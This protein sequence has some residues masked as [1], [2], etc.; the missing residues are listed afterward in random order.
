[1]EK[2]KKEFGETSVFSTNISPEGED[3]FSKNVFVYFKISDETSSYNSQKP[4]GTCVHVF[5]ET[6]NMHRNE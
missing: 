4:K 5:L 3:M 6:K 2:R 1:M